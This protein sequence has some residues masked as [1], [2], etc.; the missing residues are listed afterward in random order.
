[1]GFQFIHTAD[2]HLDCPFS[3]IGDSSIALKLIESTFKAFDR[4]IDLAIENRVAFLLIAGDIYDAKDKSL[5]AQLRF[6]KGMQ[7]LEAAKVDVYV[8]YGN[9]DPANGWTA[10]LDIPSNV[11][12]FGHGKPKSLTILKDGVHIASI[13]GWSYPKEEVQENVASQ[14]APDP[15]APYNI[16]LLHCN[17]GSSAEYEN[18]A[19]CTPTELLGAGF[20]YWAL[21][22]IHKRSVISDKNPWIVYP[23][24]PQGINPK[25]TGTKGGYLVDVGDDGATR[26]EFLETDYVRWH[27]EDIPMANISRTEEFMGLIH[28]RIDALRLRNDKSTVVRFT[29]VDHTPLHSE[30]AREGS[31]QGIIEDLRSE[32]RGEPNIVWVEAIID[33]TKPV[34]D[35][36]ERRKANDITGDF[37]R[38]LDEYRNSPSKREDL[39]KDLNALFLDRRGKRWIDPLG[40]ATLLEW[41]E[42]VET[43]GLDYLI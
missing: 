33:K 13:C 31:L 40:D 24:N 23:G 29:L 7:R 21:G 37:L 10:G 38:L 27:T 11:H 9:H 8:V 20:D 16:A 14:F 18:Y 25:E 36:E 3:G 26:L 43:V 32:E 19:P 17:C 22:H 41:L 28:S 34:I 2:L 4:I 30:L 35:L 1:M 15:K 12:L 42:Q 39:M 5:K 6:Q